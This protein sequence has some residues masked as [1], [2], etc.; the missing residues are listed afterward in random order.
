MR[1][2]ILCQMAGISYLCCV[3][4]T[5]TFIFRRWWHLSTIQIATS[6]L[7]E[8]HFTIY[9]HPEYNVNWELC[10]SLEVL[11]EILE[12]FER[13]NDQFGNG[14]SITDLLIP[15]FDP[16]KT[17]GKYWTVNMSSTTSNNSSTASSSIISSHESSRLITKPKMT[18]SLARTF[19][20]RPT[21]TAIL[22]YYFFLSRSIDWLEQDLEWHQHEKNTLYDHLFKS[23]RFRMKVQTIIQQYWQLTPRYHPYGRTPSPPGMPSDNNLNDINKPSNTAIDEETGSKQNPIIIPNDEETQRCH[24]HPSTRSMSVP[25][26]RWTPSPIDNH[27]Q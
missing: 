14:E 5:R 25:S 7:T 2:P 23:R 26:Y 13:Y 20:S 10:M 4:G 12:W 11:Y 15:P 16:F 19:A 9:F 1:I 18:C 8:D 6:P 27:V 24:F 22:R 17:I 3:M 21:S